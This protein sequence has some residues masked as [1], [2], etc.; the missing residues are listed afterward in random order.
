MLNYVNELM[1][2][3]EIVFCEMAD[4]CM[5]LGQLEDALNC[6]KN[7]KNTSEILVRYYEKWGI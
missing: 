2:N 6:L 3:Q 4:I 1:P 5:Q 7:I